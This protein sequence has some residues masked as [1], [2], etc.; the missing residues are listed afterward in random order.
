MR[1]LFISDVHLQDGTSTKARVLIR[2]LEE[3]A[4]RYD[5]LYI[6]GDLFDVWP[7]TTGHLVRHYK[8]V[9]DVLGAL[10]R[11]GTAISYLEGNHDFRLGRYFTEEIGA[12]VLENDHVDANG[13][14]W[15]GKRLY[16]SHGDLGNPKDFAYRGLRSVLRQPLL[17]GVLGLLP[18]AW[19]FALGASASRLSRKSKPPLTEEKAALIR[20]VYRE[21]ARRIC[22]RGFDLVMMGH[23]HLPDDYRFELGGRACRYLNTGD[24]VRNFT[25]VEFD[26][27][28]FHARAHPVG[29]SLS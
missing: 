15:N 29:G 10:A 6:L 8:P 7:G 2:F 24:W 9:L 4:S 26:G 18:G 22:E 21:T 3:E 11:G 12:R 1:A 17:H 25:Y 28:D 16:L 13:N 20:R 27:T 5:Q 14:D 23:T 19:V